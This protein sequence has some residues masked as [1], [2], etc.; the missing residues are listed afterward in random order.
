[1][2]IFP[3]AEIVFE[4]QLSINVSPLGLCDIEHPSKSLS[5]RMITL[6]QRPLIRMKVKERRV[7][8]VVPYVN[9]IGLGGR[10]RYIFI[11]ISNGI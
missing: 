3:F 1:M 9:A 7:V 2:F 10:R 8:S 11:V 6:Q 5:E 4:S